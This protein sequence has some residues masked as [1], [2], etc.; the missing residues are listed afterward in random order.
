MISV[1]HS[2]SLEKKKDWELLSSQSN[3]TPKRFRTPATG[4]NTTLQ[5]YFI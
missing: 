5:K 2:E 4:C 1:Q 3:K